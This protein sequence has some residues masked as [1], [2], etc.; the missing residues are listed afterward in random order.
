MKQLLM[1]LTA[2]MLTWMGTT[3]S[4]NP[5]HKMP[6]G[7]RV[8]ENFDVERYMGKWYE[9]ARLDFRFE[10]HMQETTAQY[11]LLDN[12][13]VEVIN[14]GYHTKK[15]K[16]KSVKGKA[17]FRGSEDLGA[18][19]V[20]FFGPFYSPYNV[21]ALDADYQYALVCGKNLKYLWILSRQTTIPETVKENYLKIAKD[22]GYPVEEL[23]WVKH[24]K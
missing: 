19:S 4:E 7:A 6:K 8:V 1:M 10:K 2:T 16:Y 13:K 5:D 9:I 3:Q 23:V 21:I 12:G 22:L 20:S 17:K 11:R 15:E 14:A 24:Q 18:L